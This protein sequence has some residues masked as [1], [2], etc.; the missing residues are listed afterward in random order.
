MDSPRRFTSAIRA[1]HPGSHPPTLKR[2]EDLSS[3]VYAC[4]ANMRRCDRRGRAYPPTAER[5]IGLG[6]PPLNAIKKPN[7]EHTYADFCSLAAA[8]VA[9]TW[10]TARTVVLAATANIF[11]RDDEVGCVNGVDNRKPEEEESRGKTG[12]TRSSANHIRE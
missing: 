2:S 7:R 11:L 10:A 6:K 9:L 1:D 8:L 3:H 5:S 4:G 12:S